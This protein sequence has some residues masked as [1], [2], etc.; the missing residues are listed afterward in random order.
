[1]I[2]AMAGTKLANPVTLAG[3]YHSW[4]MTD[5]KRDFHEPTSPAV[6]TEI[7]VTSITSTPPPGEGI[8]AA[9]RDNPHIRYFEEGHRGYLSV[10]LTRRSL[11]ARLMAISDRRVRDAT[12]STLHHGVVESGRA[13][14]C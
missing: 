9:L 6:A 10:D 12:L 11:E 14:W 3:D 5:L 1:M 7:A 13:G 4:W 8:K 2:D